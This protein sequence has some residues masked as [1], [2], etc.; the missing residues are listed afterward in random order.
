[1]LVVHI[2]LP[3]RRGGTHHH[4]PRDEPVVPGVFAAPRAVIV[5]VA[6]PGARVLVCLTGGV[7]EAG[8]P[9]E[10]R[11]VG[12]VGRAREIRRVRGVDGVGGVREVGVFRVRR[13]F[14]FIQVLC[15]SCALGIT[16]CVIRALCEI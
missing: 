6:F 7:R 9:G 5:F 14:E 11:E 3:V 12:E 8:E 13:A 4:A 10:V 15:T 16:T 2:R 1:M